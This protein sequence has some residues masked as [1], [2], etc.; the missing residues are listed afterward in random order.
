M[1]VE[2][3]NVSVTLR[4]NGVT[5]VFPYTFRLP[6]YEMVV[7]EILDYTTKAIVDTLTPDDYAITGVSTTNY[8][9]G[10]VTYNPSGVPLSS[11][12]ELRIRRDVD[13]ES[14]I[15]LSNQGG[16]YPKSLEYQLDQFAMQDLQL[17][18]GLSRSLRGPFGFPITE[19]PSVVNRANS[20][21]G[22]D[23]LGNPTAYEFETVPGSYTYPYAGASARTYSNK[24][25]ELGL[26]PIDM[27]AKMDGVTDDS[28][29]LLATI[30]AS[31]AL[32]LGVRLPPGRT[33]IINSTISLPAGTR[34][35]AERT[36]T[37]IGP[38]GGTTFLL[39][40]FCRIEGVRFTGTP[41]YHLQHRAASN[42]V[43]GVEIRRCVFTGGDI[44]I[45]TFGAGR[46]PNA[47]I[48]E[49]NDFVNVANP[50][51]FTYMSKGVVKFNRFSG[52]SGG[53]VVFNMGQA[54]KVV[55]NT[56]IGGKTGVTF[57]NNFAD[58]RFTSGCVE[59]NLVE[60]NTFINPEEEAVIFDI[61]GNFPERLGAR[62]TSTITA[63][64]TVDATTCFVTL[65][66]NAGSWA[67]SEAAFAGGYMVVL[68]GLA[69][70]AVYQISYNNN[71]GQFTFN[72]TGHFR[73]MSDTALALLQAGD[74]VTICTPFLSNRV[75]GNTVERDTVGGSISLYNLCIDNSVG[76]NTIIYNGVDPGS[77]FNWGIWLRAGCGWEADTSYASETGDKISLPTMGNDIYHNKITDGDIHMNFS[78][79]VTPGTANHQ[80][81][82][83]VT[84]HNRV[85]RGRRWI[86]TGADFE[87]LSHLDLIRP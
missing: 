1:T 33:M 87:D 57:I 81:R 61:A 69:T 26:S 47:W 16:F 46:K 41:Q 80:S 62:E 15:T 4:G 77:G 60:E 18:E 23:A 49:D 86:A 3:P 52:A 68:T 20:V 72:R 79:L 85:Q 55:L 31:L 64:G 19:L 30:N 54:N 48:V 51:L 5:T 12:Y 22:F 11:A 38:A 43:T 17:A 83:N 27:G 29:A 14:R 63:T 50:I 42:D 82:Y 21:L 10:S 6:E 70:S 40:D 66:P 36:S 76:N 65:S 8:S 78:N 59:Y 74:M 25:D 75:L 56:M 67:G 45:S 39:T 84:S 44:G 71:S 13:Y 28:A 24:L 58:H 35:S 53:N 34:I 37:I 32:G 73:A 9:G 2:N 7:V